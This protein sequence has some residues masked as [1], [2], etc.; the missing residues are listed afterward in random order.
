VKGQKEIVV[1]IDALKGKGYPAPVGDAFNT[2]DQK[3]NATAA[4]KSKHR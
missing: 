1:E 3:Q 2:N 4:K